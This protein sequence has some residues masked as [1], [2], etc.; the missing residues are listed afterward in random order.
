MR[1]STKE[2]SHKESSNDSDNSDVDIEADA[3]DSDR[4]EF[5]NSFASRSRARCRPSGKTA[6]RGGQ[7]STAGKSAPRSKAMDRKKK[8]YKAASL[9]MGSRRSN[10]SKEKSRRSSFNASKHGGRTPDESNSDAP[11]SGSEKELD[12]DEDGDEDE[13]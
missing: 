8:S 6:Q 12:E 5:G 7:K 2:S 1:R 13:D 9:E 4:S 10:T 3:M 11:S